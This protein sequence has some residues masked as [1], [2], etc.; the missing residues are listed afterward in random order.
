MEENR[1]DVMENRLIDQSPLLGSVNKAKECLSEDDLMALSAYL[2]DPVSA[3]L[4][5][6]NAIWNQEGN[7]SSAIWGELYKEI[8][9]KKSI[10]ITSG[11]RDRVIHLT[12]KWRAAAKD[13]IFNKLTFIFSFFSSL[14]KESS[15]QEELSEQ[16]SYFHEFTQLIMDLVDIDII[17]ENYDEALDYF[18]TEIWYD[19]FN[20]LIKEN[21]LLKC[22]CGAVI[23][24][25]GPKDSNGISIV[26]WLGEPVRK[27]S[28][29]LKL[30]GKVDKVELMPLYSPEEE[31]FA[32]YFDLLQ[33]TY[34][35]LVRQE[36]LRPLF[37]KSI[38][39]FGEK[40]YTDCVSAIGLVAEDLLTQVYETFFRKQLN[41]G[42]TLGQLADE[43]SVKVNSLYGK[44]VD[45][46][47]DF[48]GMYA[49]IQ[50]AIVSSDDQSLKALELIR[51]LLTKTIE[52]NNFL[53]NK[54][55]NI[56][57]VKPKKSLFSERVLIA[58]NELIKFRNASS[59]KSR[60][61]IGPYEATRSIYSLVIFL[62]WWESEKMSI[63]WEEP[64][65][66]IIRQSVT[67]NL[68]T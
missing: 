14:A 4:W 9:D 67:R 17:K 38:A 23:V 5:R 39:Q 48:K 11:K 51:E 61:P 15:E 66:N 41:K 32:P 6:L 28:N 56:G 36:H 63:N 46:Q 60:I 59:H 40:N 52:N 26:S 64:P 12:D 13:V 22:K 19:E 65:E 10:T 3:G 25:K 27:I 16:F 43:I 8:K 45:S 1:V 2:N 54:I 42:L 47:P 20:P 24:L 49:E 62:M 33:L 53:N 21:K 68:K 35:D 18:R 30:L 58:I 57:K 55:D 31:V 44:K 7:I 29:F 34:S 37:K 50:N